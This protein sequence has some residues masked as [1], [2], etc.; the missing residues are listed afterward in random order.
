MNN[1]SC[2]SKSYHSQIA[3]IRDSLNGAGRESIDHGAG[4]EKMAWVQR[5]WRGSREHGTGPVNMARVT[6]SEA[7]VTSSGCRGYFSLV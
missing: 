4:P 3:H 5:K 2:I 1:C 6:S 7:R